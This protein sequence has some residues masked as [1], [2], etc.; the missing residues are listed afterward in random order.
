MHNRKTGERD[1]TKSTK[2][3]TLV[4]GRKRE[5]KK[6]QV[7]YMMR[8]VHSRAIYPSITDGYFGAFPH[9]YSTRNT[10]KIKCVCL[11]MC[12]SVSRGIVHLEYG[13]FLPL[14]LLF[15]LHSVGNKS[16]LC[17]FVFSKSMCFQYFHFN[18]TQDKLHCCW[19]SPFCLF[20][21]FISHHAALFPSF[22]T[23]FV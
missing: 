2:A 11:W 13:I 7:R 20:F 4:R 5:Q 9:A 6:K 16:H 8:S 3:N 23:P 21:C 1:A 14:L 15:Q 19:R 12:T 18:G 10:T 17:A 22:C